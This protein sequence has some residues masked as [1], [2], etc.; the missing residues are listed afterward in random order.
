MPRSV[1]AW[2]LLFH[3]FRCG[4]DAGMVFEGSANLRTNGNREQLAVI[5]DRALHDWHATWIDELV[6]SD[7]GNE[8]RHQST[9]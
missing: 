7:E 6:N 2:V 4:P 8:D 5:R 1:K 3:K 9:N